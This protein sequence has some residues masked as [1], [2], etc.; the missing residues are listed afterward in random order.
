MYNSLKIIFLLSLSLL[1]VVY[2]QSSATLNIYSF[3]LSD[4]SKVKSFSLYLNKK[5]IVTFKNGE[6]ISIKILNPK[7]LSVKI[8]NRTTG[9][10]YKTDFD[11][12]NDYTYYW[13]FSTLTQYAKKERSEAIEEMKQEGTFLSDS[14]RFLVVDIKSDKLIVKDKKNIS[15]A[16]VDFG[17]EK[18][19]LSIPDEIPERPNPVGAKEIDDFVNKAFDIYETTKAFSD[20]I[21]NINSKIQELMELQNIVGNP[22]KKV[23]KEAMLIQ[24]NITTLINDSQE[25][26]KLAPNILNGAKSLKFTKIATATKNILSAV[27]AVKWSLI[28]LGELINDLP[29]I[30]SDIASFEK[31][32]NITDTEV[33]LEDIVEVQPDQVNNETSNVSLIVV[34]ESEVETQKLGPGQMILTTDTKKLLI[35]DGDKFREVV[36]KDWK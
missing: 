13:E 32:N 25:L 23:K 35:F 30:L 14:V 33:I 2:A 12:K 24:R 28:T 11:F 15:I 7:N 3:A 19:N 17:K 18:E 8:R 9:Y 10:T 16:K 26:S 21:R 31:N 4:E 20:Q 36:L 22:I 27:D 5:K 1:T 29:G 6:R 34:K